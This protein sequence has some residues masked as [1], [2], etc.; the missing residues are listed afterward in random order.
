MN[1]LLCLL[2]LMVFLLD[3]H[4]SLQL[5]MGPLSFAKKVVCDTISPNLMYKLHY[6]IQFLAIIYVFYVIVLMGILFIYN[7]VSVHMFGISQTNF[8]VFLF[9]LLFNLIFS[10]LASI[11]FF[12][13][14]LVFSSTFP[15][16]HVN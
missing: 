5:S 12:S 10:N 2:V 16:F 3:L 1:K 6:S 9:F 13:C 8:S 11:L 7:L 4:S 14:I 15:N